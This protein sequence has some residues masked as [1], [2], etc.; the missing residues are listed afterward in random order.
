MLCCTPS[1]QCTAVRLQRRASIASTSLSIF[2]LQD[3][4]GCNGCQLLPCLGPHDMCQPTA[5]VAAL[6][7]QGTLAFST[8]SESSIVCA[9]AASQ[10]A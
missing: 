9:W 10:G 4:R 3:N 8:Q 5:Y 7:R 2:D 1:G 6:C